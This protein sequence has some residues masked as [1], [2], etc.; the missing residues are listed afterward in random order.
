MN[1]SVWLSISLR[2]GPVR[3]SLTLKGTQRSTVAIRVK[4][5]QNEL[6]VEIYSKTLVGTIGKMLLMK[7][8]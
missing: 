4:K 3:W 2:G 8:S 7:Y 6:M 1:S 5:S